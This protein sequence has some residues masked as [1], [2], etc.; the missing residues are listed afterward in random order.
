MVKK[1]HNQFHV[2]LLINIKIQKLLLLIG[3]LLW[4]YI[5]KNMEL[6]SYIVNN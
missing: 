5:I 1:Y 3:R 6:R 4:K 2:V